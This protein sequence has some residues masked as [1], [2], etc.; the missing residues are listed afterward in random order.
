MVKLK[1]TSIDFRERR[2]RGTKQRERVRVELSV[3]VLLAE[4]SAN[5]P[6]VVE[7]SLD[8]SR[9]FFPLQLALLALFNAASG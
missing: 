2:V 5:E 1:K 3:R 6:N 7:K 8:E 4:S 9:E